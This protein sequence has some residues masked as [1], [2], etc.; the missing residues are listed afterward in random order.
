MTKTDEYCYNLMENAIKNG[1]ENSGLPKE[2]CVAVMNMMSG[3]R[4][5]EAYINGNKER[6]VLSDGEEMGD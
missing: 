2:A 5:C 1:A 6:E 3:V 4:D